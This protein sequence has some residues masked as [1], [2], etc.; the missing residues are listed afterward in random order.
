LAAWVV[1][2]TKERK[3]PYLIAAVDSAGTED[4]RLEG[5]D[6]LPA[7]VLLKYRTA[8]RRYLVMAEIEK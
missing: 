2:A 3:H 8:A 6:P 4:E 7:N 1:E 5:Q